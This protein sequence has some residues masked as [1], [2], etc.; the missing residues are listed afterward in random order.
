MTMG[1][2]DSFTAGQ[3]EWSSPGTNSFFTTANLSLSSRLGARCVRGGAGGGA[4]GEGDL[5]SEGMA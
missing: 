2:I 3:T 5:G 1:I 4:W